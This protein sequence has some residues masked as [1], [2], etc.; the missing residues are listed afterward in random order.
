MK[1]CIDVALYLINNFGC[2]G[3]EQFKKLLFE[4]CKYGRLDVVKDMVEQHSINPDGEYQH[5]RLSSYCC[6]IGLI[7]WIGWTSLE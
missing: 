6:N 3:T 2:G 5:I 7:G 4:A 1:E